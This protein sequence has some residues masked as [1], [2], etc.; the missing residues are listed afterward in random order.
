MYKLQKAFLVAFSITIAVLFGYLWFTD[1]SDE[2]KLSIAN[3]RPYGQWLQQQ[4]IE[5]KIALIVIAVIG[6]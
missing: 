1:T 4:R 3:Q 2:L 6:Y 5:L